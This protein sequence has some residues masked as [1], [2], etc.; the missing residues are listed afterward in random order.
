MQ[1]LPILPR[2]VSSTEHAAHHLQVPWSQAL[3]HKLKTRKVLLG[4][5]MLHSCTCPVPCL[6]FE[7]CSMS[8]LVVTP[9]LCLKVQVW[10]QPHCAHHGADMAGAT[11]AVCQAA[12]PCGG[13][14]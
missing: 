11:V 1:G 7:D 4:A 13:A 9:V 12:H 3:C 6:A 5:P 10:S 2:G 14:G 8:W